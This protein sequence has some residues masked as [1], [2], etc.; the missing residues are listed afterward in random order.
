M[1]TAQITQAAFKLGVLSWTEADPVS[2]AFVVNADWSGTYEAQI[3]KT[4][5]K[6]GTLVGEFTV[7]ADYDSVDW[8][9]ATLFT[10]TITQPDSALIP[11]QS[12]SY[13]TDIQEIGGVT[14]LW[15]EVRVDQQVS[16]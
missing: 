5:K 14:R 11:A 9:L 6:T 16:V 3:R 12:A 2:L 1:A 13:F 15:A 8:P 10:L 7:V 4:H